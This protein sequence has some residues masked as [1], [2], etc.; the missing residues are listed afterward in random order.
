MPLDHE[1]LDVYDLALE[2]VLLASGIIEGLP[3]GRSGAACRAAAY[4]LS[5][6]DRDGPCP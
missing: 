1:R 2:L 4:R 3:R 6:R 5:H